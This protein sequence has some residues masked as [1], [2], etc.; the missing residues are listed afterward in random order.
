MGN[1]FQQAKNLLYY[2]LPPLYNPK[3]NNDILTAPS[4]IPA[5]LHSGTFNEFNFKQI[6]EESHGLNIC[7]WGPAQTD[8]KDNQSITYLVDRLEHRLSINMKIIKVTPNNISQLSTLDVYTA[9][10]PTKKVLIIFTPQCICDDVQRHMYIQLRA[11]ASQRPKTHIIQMIESDTQYDKENIM[12]SNYIFFMQSPI[13]GSIKCYLME[14]LHIDTDHIE[15]ITTD[16]LLLNEHTA[17]VLDT[18][19]LTTTFFHYS[20]L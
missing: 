11:K 2:S 14:I 7:V 16:H 9:A 19:T 15:H 6:S 3:E 20:L 12:N 17:L 18:G 13:V 5:L 8:K 1:Y 10:P 4:C